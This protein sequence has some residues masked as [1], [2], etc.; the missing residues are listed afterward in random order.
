MFLQEIMKQIVFRA[1]LT[2]GNVE[3][4]V[5]LMLRPFLPNILQ[6]CTGAS[7]VDWILDEFP[8]KH[9][10][11][12]QADYLDDLCIETSRC[13]DFVEYKVRS[14][15]ESRDKNQ[16]K[17]YH[18]WKKKIESKDASVLLTQLKIIRSNCADPKNLIKHT[19]IINYLKKWEQE[20]HKISKASIIYIAPDAYFKSLE[21][22]DWPKPDIM[23]PFS[24]LPE[25]IEDS[26]YK[27]EWGIIH[28]G[29]QEINEKSSQ[30]YEKFLG[31]LRRE[32]AIQVV[33]NHKN[34]LVKP[35]KIAFSFNALKYP[36]Y[37]AIYPDESKKGF[38]YHG[39]PFIYNGKQS[40]FKESKLMAPVSYETLE[41]RARS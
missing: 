24:Q 21:K 19:N 31:P 10:I 29:L 4:R 6:I 1:G 35:I 28:K 40:E 26:V 2:N 39:K 20:L 18:N 41:K 30:N 32:C 5:K 38:Y 13:F 17:I 22:V 37:N 34:D 25:N 33:E 23:I 9:E 8:L 11:N 27:E 14:H 15:I 12:C 16:L 7:K 3:D 36:N